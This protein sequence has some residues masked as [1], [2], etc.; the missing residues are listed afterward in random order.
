MNTCLSA[1]DDR[2]TPDNAVLTSMEVLCSMW[3]PAQVPEK[4]EKAVFT[5]VGT[6]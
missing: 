6:M 2:E 4:I 5:N 3:R 1:R